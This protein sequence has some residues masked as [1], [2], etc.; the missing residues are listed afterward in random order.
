M[1]PSVLRDRLERVRRAIEIMRYTFRQTR[2]DRP[3]LDRLDDAAFGA[4]YRRADD[5]LAE[6]LAAIP[7][8]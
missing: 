6:V 1:T 5:A 2:A 3:D 4:A 8:R 7:D